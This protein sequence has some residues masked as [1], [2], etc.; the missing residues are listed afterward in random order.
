MYIG[1]IV[2]TQTGSGVESAPFYSHRYHIYK[3]LDLQIDGNKIALVYT[4]SVKNHPYIHTC[5]CSFLSLLSTCQ[6]SVQS[7][8][9]IFRFSFLLWTAV[10]WR[11]NTR[12]VREVDLSEIETEWLVLARAHI[13]ESFKQFTSFISHSP[14]ARSSYF[15]SVLQQFYFLSCM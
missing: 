3:D 5:R 10:T 4:F 15:Y 8:F 14:S 11:D 6:W 13:H 7:A 2:I 9:F 1:G 12:V